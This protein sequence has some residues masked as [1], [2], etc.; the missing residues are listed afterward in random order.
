MYGI[1]TSDFL[2]VADLYGIFYKNLFEKYQI[3]SE[4]SWKSMMISINILFIF[5]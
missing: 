2:K 4:S 3:Y 5:K 1:S